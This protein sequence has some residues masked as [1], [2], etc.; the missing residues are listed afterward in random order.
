[1][2]DSSKRTFA[3]AFEDYEAWWNAVGR[4][5]IDAMK[6]CIDSECDVDARSRADETAVAGCRIQ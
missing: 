6:G 5:D 4:G 2:V 1:M 3:E